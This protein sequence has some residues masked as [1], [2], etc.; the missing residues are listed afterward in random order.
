MQRKPNRVTMTSPETDEFDINGAQPFSRNALVSIKASAGTGKTYSLTT[1]VVRLVAEQGIRADQILL[2]TFT[3]EAT[4]ELR[5]ETRRRCREALAALAGIGKA[6]PWMQHMES[7]DVRDV[8]IARLEEFL[9]RYDEVTISTIHGFCQSVLRQAGLDGEA[10]ADFEVVPNIDG[11]IDQ[12]I[13]DLLAGR[14]SGSASYLYGTKWVTKK[15][16]KDATIVPTTISN[17]ATT[18]NNLRKVVKTILN[19]EGAQLLPAPSGT[20]LGIAPMEDGISNGASQFKIDTLAQK[21]ADTART[22]VDE[23]R[24]RCLRAG[25]VTY[26][27]IV[28]LVALA[29]NSP[30]A[31]GKD[32]AD[33]LASQYPIVM[34]DEFQDTDAVQW[35]IF[36]KILEAGQGRVTLITVGDPKQA[37]YR[38]RGADVNVYLAASKKADESF[39]LRTNRRSDAPLLKALEVILENETFDVKGDVTFKPVN[40]DVSNKSKMTY[41]LG[42]K[43]GVEAEANLPATPMEIRWIPRSSSFE[44]KDKDPDERYSRKS[45]NAAELIRTTFFSDMAARIVDFLNWATIPDSDATDGSMR[46]VRPSDIA[47]LVDT[48][49]EAREAVRSLQKVQVGAVKLKT[50][51]VFQTEAAR[52]WL[53]LL[54][55]LANPGRPRDVRTY[56]LSWFGGLDEVSLLGDVKLVID[57]QRRCANH[58]ELMQRE[59][60]TAL[61]MAYRSSAEFLTNVLDDPDG[62]RN[63]TDLDHIAETLGSMPEFATSAGPLE[64]L[65]VLSD[66]IDNAD[67]DADEQKRRIDTDHDSVTVMTIHSSK[68][69]QFPI[70]ILPTLNHIKQRRG[71]L[72][73]PAELADGVEPVRVIDV[74]SPFENAQQWIFKPTGASG[75]HIPHMK[76]RGDDKKPHSRLAMTTEDIAADARRLFYVAMTRAKHKLICYWSPIGQGDPKDPFS[77]SITR[78]ADLQSVPLERDDLRRAFDTLVTKSNGSISHIEIT[79]NVRKVELIEKMDGAAGTPPDDSADVATFERASESVAVYGYGRWSYST[80]TKGLK[81]RALLGYRETGA[82]A[83][84]GASDESN[85]E[86]DDA[87]SASNVSPFAWAGLPAGAG[88]GNDVHMLLDRIDPAT[89]DLGAELAAAVTE[90]F[91]AFG[92]GLDR[93]RLASAIAANLVVK[94]ADG[95]EGRSLVDLGR[96]HRLSELRFDFPLPRNS[97]VG[98]HEI[99]G[100]AVKY[101]DLPTG[102]LDDFERMVEA[103]SGSARIAG[104]MNGSI[105]A[106]FRISGD[107]PR[108][109]VCDY[110]TNKLHKDDDPNPI[111]SYGRASME[112]AMLRDGYFFQAMI[113]SVALQRYL[114]QRQPGYDFDKNFAGV[115]YLFLRGLDG[116]ID[117]SGYQRGN[118]FWKPSKALIDGL[119]TLFTEKK[120]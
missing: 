78:A 15:G 105:D 45:N 77:G 59:G 23:V 102:V 90:I 64:C 72:M 118:Y 60:I 67:S 50:G 20:P 17:V 96:K 75:G 58:A 106:V 49:A 4:G 82:A 62:V 43:D 83:L 39:D 28:R 51:S 41:Q 89:T 7:K 112:E 61:Y 120:Q 73:F 37:I 3:N 33:Q 71:A 81:S 8:A 42:V 21:I 38:F 1:T 111:E 19:N 30:S 47:I 70:V 76:E 98:V 12:A 6:A 88:F 107:Q 54:K 114:R 16:E 117:A 44:A 32:L 86:D 103:M 25:I 85:T 57:L 84:P 68:G 53:M 18:L 119:D 14:L 27:D 29:L 63:L 100:L 74:A 113:Y 22:I 11:I 104:F 52:H 36:G 55:A 10:P 79:D 92:D 80:V 99:V 110:K 109:I 46:A 91:P 65:D 66:L 69:L 116:S 9:A 101:G 97:S 13:T 115:S 93:T 24:E 26:N 40:A 2:M 56:A 48:H 94:L 108:Y 31:D 5:L 87:V 95:F 34:I 35:Q